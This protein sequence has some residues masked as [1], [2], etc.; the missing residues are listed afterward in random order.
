MT[1]EPRKVTGEI[2]D[3]GAD[4]GVTRAGYWLRRFKID[5]LPQLWNVLV[6]DMSLVGPRPAMPQQL[7]ELDEV[8]RMRLLVRPGLTG[9]AQVNGNIFL[10][11]PQR[12]QFDRQYVENVTFI[13]DVGIMLRTALVILLGERRFAKED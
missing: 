10:T 2:R 4:V 8:G 3:S 6:G 13:T 7:D 1:D 5:E 12:W 11:W 9:L